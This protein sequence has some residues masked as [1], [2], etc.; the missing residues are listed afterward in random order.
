MAIKEVHFMLKKLLFVLLFIPFAITPF[1]DKEFQKEV[2]HHEAIFLSFVQKQA[3]NLPSPVLI[4]IKDIVRIGKK[5]FRITRK[6]SIPHPTHTIKN[7]YEKNAYNH[8][9]EKLISKMNEVIFVLLMQ[10]GACL[11]QYKTIINGNF[12][13]TFEVDALAQLIENKYPKIVILAGKRFDSPADLIAYLANEDVIELLEYLESLG[14]KTI[15]E[16]NKSIKKQKA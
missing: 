13:P 14:D 4:P 8:R 5:V 3:T 15:Q 11:E 1:T 6:Y 16:L 10:H 2:E 7:I 12:D 9:I